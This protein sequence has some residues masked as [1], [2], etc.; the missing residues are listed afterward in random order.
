MHCLT[1]GAY[2]ENDNRYVA[3]FIEKNW[4]I[5]QCFAIFYSC[6]VEGLIVKKWPQ[7]MVIDQ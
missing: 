2:D 3:F 4:A 6:G 5:V 1:A 7:P